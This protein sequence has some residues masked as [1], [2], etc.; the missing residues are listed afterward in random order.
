M[1]TLKEFHPVQIILI[2]LI[3]LSLI[4]GCTEDT[5][6]EPD[7]TPVVDNSDLLV[8]S[9]SVAL[10]KQGTQTVSVKAYDKDGKPE[11]CTVTSE[12][13]GVASVTSSGTSFTVTG[14]DYGSTNIIVTSNSGKSKEL[15]VTIYDLQIL[16][17][18]ELLITYA[19]TYEF[20]W[21]DIGSG[22]SWDGS[23]YHPITTDGF[24]SLGSLGF[25]NYYNP[26]NLLGI[27][28]VKAKPG[29]DA[30]A[31]PTDYTLVYN[32]IGSGANSDGSFWTPV[33]PSGYKAM[34]LVAQTGYL[35]PSLTDV[36][37]VREDLTIPGEAGA[38]IWNDVSTGANMSLGTWQIDPPIAG[39]HENAYLST[40]TFVGWNSWNPPSTHPVMNILNVKLP[41]LAETPYQQYVPSLTGFDPP[42]EE[43]IPIL[44]REMLVPCTIVSDPL[45]NNNQMW[46]VSNS[47]FYRLERQVFYKLLYHNHNQTSIQ[48]HNSYT[49]RYGVTTEES[50][51]F[52]TETSISVTV[53]AGISIKIFD[54]KVSTTVSTSM[55]Y[56]TMTSVSELEESEYE[57]GVD[58]LPGK[59]VAIWQRYNRFV[60]KR[61]NGTTLEAVKAWEFGI[62][63][64]ITDEYPDE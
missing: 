23:F 48:Q 22:G 7:L 56:S 45:Y 8:N 28:I 42:Q 49:R 40:G 24:F 37:C 50:N 25:K 1:K 38:F 12:N 4:P 62:N 17:T 14:V 53:E 13:G 11:N 20:R 64:F 19:Q 43:T 36:V 3:S 26:D 29:S 33:P 10:V 55:G 31:H 34:G 21:N 59:A 15:P 57:S 18:E 16:E 54:A 9:L 60:L 30:I 32:D 39:A 63:S 58:V 27:M 5:S 35:K 41:M 6:T 2:I 44:A 51:E 46:R 47:P 61:H 52:W